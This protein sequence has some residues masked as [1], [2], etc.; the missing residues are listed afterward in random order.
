MNFLCGVH[1]PIKLA[2]FLPSKGHSA[3]HVN[4]L[5]AKWHTN[6]SEI[7]L[8]TNQNECIVITKDEDFRASFLLKRT[9]R[10]LIHISL[11]NISNN[12][13]IELFSRHLELIGEVNQHECF[14]L[15][16]GKMTILY[17]F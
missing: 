11:G 4:Q 8:I 13:L 17:T 15:E 12:A 1:I 3:K 9:P 10:K 16:L 14:F 2:K 7:C 5:P 6:D